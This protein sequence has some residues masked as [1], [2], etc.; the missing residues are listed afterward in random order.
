[1]SP[2]SVRDSSAGSPGASDAVRGTLLIHPQDRTLGPTWGSL[3]DR[4]AVLLGDLLHPLLDLR[5][6]FLEFRGVDVEVH[7]RLEGGIDHGLCRTG[8]WKVRVGLYNEN[9]GG[10]PS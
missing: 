6:L 3:R 9:R 7:Q 2:P 4:L 8:V 1:M 5:G 10:D